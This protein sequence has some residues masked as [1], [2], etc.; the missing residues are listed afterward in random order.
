MQPMQTSKQ[1]LIYLG[2]HPDNNESSA[3]DRMIRRILPVVFVV[4]T[5][6]AMLSCL[7]FIIKF[8]RINMEATLFTAMVTLVYVGLAFI[9]AFAFVSRSDVASVFEELS[10]IHQT[11]APIDSIGILARANSTSEWMWSIF[12]R[13]L[14]C[15][16]F[17][18]CTTF[19]L[20][21]FFN[22]SHG[23][24][25]VDQFYRPYY[26]KWVAVA[27]FAPFFLEK[28]FSWT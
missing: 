18:M 28:S 14:P 16:F 23:I 3:W 10:E 5:L 4:F 26:S 24:Y 15:V 11:T 25:D 9:I 27:F 17:G 12:F 21:Y 2:L 22:L 6:C 13:I 19:G 8:S 20:M 7:S 1:V